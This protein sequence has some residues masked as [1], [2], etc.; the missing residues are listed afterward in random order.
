MIIYLILYLILYFFYFLYSTICLTVG[1]LIVDKVIVIFN[2]F[3]MF[4]KY[5][6]LNFELARIQYP[7]FKIHY[8]P[9]KWILNTVNKMNIN[10]TGV[11]VLVYDS[12]YGNICRR[13]SIVPAANYFRYLLLL[14]TL[15]RRLINGSI[16]IVCLPS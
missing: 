3:S 11:D 14:V 13:Q 15:M 12:H 16:S 6:I 1:P 5:W 7:I 9:Q 2:I 8:Q 10:E 4:L